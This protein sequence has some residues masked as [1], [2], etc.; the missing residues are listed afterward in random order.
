MSTMGRTRCWPWIVSG[1]L[2]L[3][4][5]NLVAPSHAGEE[6]DSPPSEKSAAEEKGAEKAAEAASMSP[7]EWR[8]ALAELREAITGDDEEAA[9]G[10]MAA[11]A[12]IDDVNAWQPLRDLVTQ[13][14]NY[15]VRCLAAVPLGRIRA[16][17]RKPPPDDRP[18]ETMTTAEWRHRLKELRDAYEGEDKEAK[19][20]ARLEIVNI[21]DPGALG[22]I[23]QMLALEKD[24]LLRRELLMPLARIGGRAA[25]REL[26]ELSVKGGMV[27]G[28]ASLGLA[29]TDEAPEAV[30]LLARYLQ[31]RKYQARAVQ[32]LATSQI[33]QPLE[34]GEKP[35]QR[36]TVGL[37]DALALKTPDRVM[38]PAVVLSGRGAAMGISSRGVQWAYRRRTYRIRNVAVKVVNLSP[39]GTALEL[40][41]QYSGEDHQFD[42][43]A[44]ADWYR[45]TRHAAQDS[46]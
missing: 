36:L 11:L 18:L 17:G 2:L 42:Q 19:E 14:K 20:A 5:G 9:Q 43:Q 32:A 39:N 3:L 25:V 45:Q 27:D 12:G 21:R 13:E 30:P 26:V 34:Q 10:A 23:R 22:V 15:K 35:D 28:E 29:L 40:L 4:A 7:D 41:K 16:S 44:W 8:E 24:N 6:T 38:M 1:S 33:L 37:I 46:P 31:N